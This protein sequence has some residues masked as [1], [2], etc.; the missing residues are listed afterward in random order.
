MYVSEIS[1]THIRGIVGGLF[2]VSIGIGILVGNVLGLDEVK[3]SNRFNS[4]MQI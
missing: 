2:S 3:L 4:K 1:A